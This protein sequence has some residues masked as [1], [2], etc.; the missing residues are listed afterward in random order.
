MI[1]QTVGLG[2]TTRTRRTPQRTR[3]DLDERRRLIARQRE[4]VESQ[5]DDYQRRTAVLSDEGQAR[6]GRTSRTGRWTGYE[7]D[8]RP[9]S[10]DASTISV[11][12]PDL[13]D[14]VPAGT[15]SGGSGQVGPTQASLFGGN[16]TML[17]LGAGV[18]LGGAFLFVQMKD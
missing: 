18:L 8:P 13:L 9:P 7:S 1:M 12:S 10:G 17:L 11:E 4:Y 15:Q 5:G 6:K 2:R 16:R 14:L 3:G